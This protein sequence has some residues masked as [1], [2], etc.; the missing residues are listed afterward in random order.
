[1]D[2]A[3]AFRTPKAGNASA[4]KKTASHHRLLMNTFIDPLGF[5]AAIY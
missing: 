1:M 5:G 4:D 3:S 2:D